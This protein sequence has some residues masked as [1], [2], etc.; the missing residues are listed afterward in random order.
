L[1]D[2]IFFLIGIAEG[3]L[4]VGLLMWLARWDAKHPEIPD[5]AA[6]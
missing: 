6:K 3:S 4:I 5:Q 1:P 2:W